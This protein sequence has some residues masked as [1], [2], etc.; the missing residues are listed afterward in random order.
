VGILPFVKIPT[1]A[2]P[3]GSGRPDFGVIGLAS[4]E[5]PASLSLD[6]NLGVAAIG[7]S[8]RDDFH[9]QAQAAVSLGHKV[10][11][12]LTVF[13]EVFFASREQRD[14]SETVGF[15]AG[16]IWIAHRRLALDLGVETTL[17]G[18]GPDFGVRVGF[19]VLF[20][21]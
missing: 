6:I 1:A 7:Q 21:R 16:V 20:R 3:I 19:T 4:F 5:F 18:R 11:E 10:F 2:E 14:A 17:K 12:P 15:D 9:P 8:D 13:G